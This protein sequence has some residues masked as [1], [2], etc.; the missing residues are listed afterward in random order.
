MHYIN[1]WCRIVVAVDSLMRVEALS[2]MNV[3][4]TSYINY[5]RLQSL[6][7]EWR[8]FLHCP[9]IWCAFL[10]NDLNNHRVDMCRIFLASSKPRKV[11]VFV[12]LCRIECVWL[13]DKWRDATWPPTSR[14]NSRPRLD[15]R[16]PP[17]STTTRARALLQTKKTSDNVTKQGRRK[18]EE[19]PIWSGSAKR[20]TT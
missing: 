19:P 11:Y 14:P 2:C 10:L 4:G 12:C 3:F 17:P 15:W 1:V 7:D 13:I 20:Y 6:W 16:A 8:R 5:Y 18:Q 9:T